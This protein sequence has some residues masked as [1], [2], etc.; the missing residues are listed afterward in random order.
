MSTESK[1]KRSHAP[2]LSDHSVADA[3]VS[4]VNG[5][6]RKNNDEYYTT[7]ELRIIIMEYIM[8]IFL[9]FDTTH[10]KHTRDILQN[11]TFIHTGTAFKFLV[12]SEGRNKASSSKY[13]NPGPI[14][15]ACSTGYDEGIHEWKIKI[16]KAS[17]RHIAFGII[18]NIDQ[19]KKSLTLYGVKGDAYYIQ[20]DRICCG[21]HTVMKLRRSKKYTI[22]RWSVGDI[23]TV[24]LNCEKW[25]CKF[26]ING[27]MVGC[28]FDIT[29]NRKY[30]AA[31]ESNACDNKLQLVSTKHTY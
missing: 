5:Y 6:I 15:Y 28:K 10:T 22:K 19:C 21:C 25:T 9:R 27:K 11:G 12:R 31:I 20:Y 14:I 2:V 7:L 1:L 18:T 8:D 23:I 29:Q 16:N 26:R 24:H 13:V 30:H 17:D 3:I 4:L